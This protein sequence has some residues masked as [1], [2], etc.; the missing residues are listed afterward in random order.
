MYSDS[1]SPMTFYY[2]PGKLSVAADQ[3]GQPEISFLQ[4]RY[5]GTEATGDGGD[6]RTRSILSFKVGM[7]PVTGEK[8]AG[9]R[10]ELRKAG[11]QVNLLKPLPMRKIETTLN[12]TPIVGSDEQP[13][14][15]KDTA[16]KPIG[17]GSLE[18]SETKDTTAGYWT[19]RVFTI[20]P[21]NFTSQALWDAFQ[22]GK[23]MLSLTYSFYSDGIPPEEQKPVVE[24][25]LPVEVPAELQPKQESDSEKKRDPRIVLT[26]T[27]A[28]TVDA[29]SYPSRFQRV[30]I[31]ESVPPGY[32]ALSVYCYDFNNSIRPDLYLKAV[33]IEA[34]SVEGETVRN[35][36]TFTR[37]SPDVYS[38][39][40]KFRFAVSLKEP[41]KYRIRELTSDGKE[42]MKPWQ[43]AKSWTGILDVTTPPE[44]RPKPKE[45]D[46]GDEE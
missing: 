31:N 41:Y 27:V 5:M 3:D 45:S 2:G 7:D 13:A 8:L 14:E 1:D 15:A 20:A 12:Y 28:V 29:K 46:S 19:E 38:A 16:A 33:E 44:D 9:L 25:N 4:M 24:S 18:K 32:A 10:S 43:A 11:K 40:V 37:A 6:F 30:D 23:V 39:T 42:K 26:D 21:D 22:T 17:S 34:V 36:A 35:E